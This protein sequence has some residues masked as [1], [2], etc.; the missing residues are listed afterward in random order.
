ME[1]KIAYLCDGKACSEKQKGCQTICF[2]TTKIEH[3]KNFDL[4]EDG[5][6]YWAELMANERGQR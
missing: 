4:V 6:G 3:A 2:H 5:S 1:R